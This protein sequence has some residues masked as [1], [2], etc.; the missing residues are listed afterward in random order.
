M[1]PCGADV[2]RGE[3]VRHRFWF[4][5]VRWLARRLGVVQ[6]VGPMT[7]LGHYGHKLKVGHNITSRG[8]LPEHYDVTIW[9]ES[10]RK[11]IILCRYPA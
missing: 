11:N 10:C 9:C 1:V 8:N 5:L 6:P 2:R 7:I 3:G 4:W